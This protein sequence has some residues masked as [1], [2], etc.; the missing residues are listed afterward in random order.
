MFKV[1]TF[2]EMKLIL[3]LGIYQTGWEN[4]LGKT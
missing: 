3:H 1:F 4:V 2:W